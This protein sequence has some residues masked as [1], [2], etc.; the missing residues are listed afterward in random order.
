[1]SALNIIPNNDVLYSFDYQAERDQWRAALKNPCAQRGKTLLHS[2]HVNCLVGGIALTWTT[3]PT[4][5]AGAARGRVP[6]L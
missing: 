1:M 3:K 6:D 2:P 4:A 5:A